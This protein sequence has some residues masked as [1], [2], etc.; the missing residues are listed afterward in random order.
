MKTRLTATVLA[1]LVAGLLACSLAGAAMVTLSPQRHGLEHCP[2]RNDQGRRAQL[3]RGGDGS[4][5]KIEVGK[6]T[7]SCS[8]RTPVIGRDLEIAATERLLE[9]DPAENPEQAYL[10]LELRAGGGAKYQLLVYHCSARRRSP[11]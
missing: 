10:G 3:R 2:R 9:R 4:A 7:P 8:Y 11:G 5:L 6:L 1:A